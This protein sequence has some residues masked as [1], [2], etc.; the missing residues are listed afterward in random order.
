MLLLGLAFVG[1][2]PNNPVT[3][4]GTRLFEWDVSKASR[5]TFRAATIGARTVKDY[6]IT[7]DKQAPFVL[8]LHVEVAPV[9]FEEGGSKVSQIAPVAIRGKVNANDAWDLSGKCQD[10]PNYKM[11]TVDATGKMTTPPGMLQDC[12]VRFH[13]SSGVLFKST[14]QLGTTLIVSGDGTVTAFPEHDAKIE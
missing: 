2:G 10:G 14:Y 8:D 6:K 4:A 9:E 11:G 7:L 1:C 13:R 3:P 5:T 12:N